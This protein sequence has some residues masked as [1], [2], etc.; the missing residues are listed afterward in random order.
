MS[1]TR[2]SNKTIINFAIFGELY[3]LA[4]RGYASI[5]FVGEA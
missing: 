3:P 4:L 5:F 1:N 2:C